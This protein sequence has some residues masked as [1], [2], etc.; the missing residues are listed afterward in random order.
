VS[1]IALKQTILPDLARDVTAYV[2]SMARAIRIDDFELRLTAAGIDAEHAVDIGADLNAYK[3][4]DGQ[5]ACY[6][7]PWIEHRSPDCR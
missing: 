5:S 4:V 2:G 3:N 1:D 7:Q 6:S